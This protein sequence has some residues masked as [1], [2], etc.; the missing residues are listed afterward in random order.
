[1]YTEKELSV[2]NG[3]REPE[4]IQSYL[5]NLTYDMFFFEDRA[6]DARSFRRTVLEQ[7]GAC[8][9]A[10]LTAAHLLEFQGFNPLVMILWGDVYTHS[11][12]I[13]NNGHIGSLGKGLFYRDSLKEAKFPDVLSLARDFRKDFRKN[14]ESINCYTLTDLN[15][16]DIDW[17]F[18]MG[19]LEDEYLIY[20]LVNKAFVQVD[21]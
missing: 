18:G 13:Y 14:G 8:L 20:Y 2:I 4:D 5:D 12:A 6:I 19:N 10:A 7:K 11:V 16:I 1:M 17:R 3:C 15:D 21:L 9:C